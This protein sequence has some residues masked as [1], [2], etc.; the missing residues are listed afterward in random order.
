MIT[1]QLGLQR[2]IND[3]TKRDLGKSTVS[4][5]TVDYNTACMAVPLTWEAFDTELY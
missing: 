1:L 3:K 2:V 5:L 4:P